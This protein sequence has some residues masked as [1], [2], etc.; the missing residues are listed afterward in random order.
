[1]N[2]FTICVCI[3]VYVRAAQVALPLRLG[4]T[5]NA[6]RCDPQT[7]AGIVANATATGCGSAADNALLAPAPGPAAASSA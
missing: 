1:M 7:S 3:Y 6:G 4:G 2:G 5:I